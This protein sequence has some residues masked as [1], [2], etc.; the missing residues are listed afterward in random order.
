MKSSP[1][2]KK[3][4]VLAGSKAQWSFKSLRC[5]LNAATSCTLACDGNDRSRLEKPH[6]VKFLNKFK[7]TIQRN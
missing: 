3:A 6:Q 1:V 2:H 4:L 7:I 5:R